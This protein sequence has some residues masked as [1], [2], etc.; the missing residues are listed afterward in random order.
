MT[1][2]ARKI[3]PAK[4]L[5]VVSAPPPAG[6]EDVYV[7]EDG[8]V[9]RQFFLA[10]PIKRLGRKLRDGDYVHLERYARP[11]G[12]PQLVNTVVRQ[13]KRRGGKIDFQPLA[14]RTASKIA[15]RTKVVGI[16]VGHQTWYDIR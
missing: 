5:P 6:I 4:E 13:V 16:V 7:I 1:R 9:P 2:P 14:G 15:A 10:I 8:A 12:G 3:A 11:T